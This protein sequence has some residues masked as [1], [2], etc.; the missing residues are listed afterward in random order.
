MKIQIPDIL[1][2]E[3]LEAHFIQ[4]RGS[5]NSTEGRSREVERREHHFAEI[6]M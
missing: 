4:D 1:I 6:V 3:A 2:Q 5:I